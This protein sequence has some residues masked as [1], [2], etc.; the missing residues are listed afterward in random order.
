MTV[1]YAMKDGI[2]RRKEQ[3]NQGRPFGEA[4]QRWVRNDPSL[5][6]D[7]V[8]AAVCIESYGPL[9]HNNWDIYALLRRQYKPA[10]MIVIPGGAHALSRQPERLLSLQGNVDWFRFWLLGG[11]RQKPVLRGETAAHLQAQYARWR[12]MLDLE[13]ADE[14]RPR[15][16][17]EGGAD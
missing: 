3:A 4:L 15:C 6:T 11:E 12:Q 13:R 10:E 8:R 17:R 2:L 1:T 5:H 16:V 7:C 14:A 9:V